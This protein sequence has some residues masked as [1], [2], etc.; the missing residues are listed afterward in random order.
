MKKFG[1][2]LLFIICGFMAFLAFSLPVAADT[3]NAQPMYRSYNPN[4]SEHF[5]TASTYERDSLVKVGWKNSPSHHQNMIN[6]WH[7]FGIGLVVDT[8]NKA[9]ASSLLLA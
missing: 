3:S 7:Y 5:Y 8:K 4:S 1:K 9:V 2:L 6:D